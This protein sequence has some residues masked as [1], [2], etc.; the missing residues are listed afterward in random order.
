MHVLRR[1]GFNDCCIAETDFP[2]IYGRPR[3]Y[4]PAL[5][6]FT[7][8]S[9]YILMRLFTFKAPQDSAGIAHRICVIGFYTE[10]VQ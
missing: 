8:S 7:F 1:R 6:T 9:A 10:L 2:F 4:A 5:A 3:F